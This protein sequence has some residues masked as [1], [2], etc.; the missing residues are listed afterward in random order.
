MNAIMNALREVRQSIPRRLLEECFLANRY[1]HNLTPRSVESVIEQTVIDGR[2][3]LDVNIGTGVEVVIPLLGVPYEL[4]DTWNK[5]YIV[6]KELSQG[7]SITSVMSVGYGYGYANTS[8]AYPAPQG[9]QIVGAANSLV[10][11]VSQV[12]VSSTAQAW[13]V[14]ENVVAIRDTY[15]SSPYVHLR[16]WLEHDRE[17]SNINPRSYHEFNKLVT[18]ATKAKIYNDLVLEQDYAFIHGGQELGVLKD[19]LNSYSEANAEYL[20][21]LNTDWRKVAYHND[22][23]QLRRIASHTFPMFI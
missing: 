15:N 8:Q 9:S 23:E 7:R 11:S 10:N 22:P 2:V 1:Y 13:L 20:E 6:P 16:C 4:I 12:Q 19:V 17:M 18:L 14:G 3:R 5:V 21:F